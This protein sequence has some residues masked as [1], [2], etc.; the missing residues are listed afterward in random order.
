MISLLATLTIAAL[1]TGV[2][3]FKHRWGKLALCIAAL[4][5]FMLI[6]LYAH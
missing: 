5:L 1:I 3:Q 4:A 2:A 6:V